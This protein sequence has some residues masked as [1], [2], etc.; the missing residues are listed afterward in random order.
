MAHFLV[1]QHYYCYYHWL[2]KVKY[3]YFLFIKA[4]DVQNVITIF[5]AIQL[6]RSWCWQLLQHLVCDRLQVGFFLSR[7]VFR[8]LLDNRIPY[9]YDYGTLKKIYILY[10]NSIRLFYYTFDSPLFDPEEFH[11]SIILNWCE[12]LY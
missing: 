1:Y 6:V 8:I 11:L 9:A 4:I 7:L 10:P 2:L 3:L 5:F 12:P